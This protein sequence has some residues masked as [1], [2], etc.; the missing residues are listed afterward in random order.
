MSCSPPVLHLPS[1]NIVVGFALGR[2]KNVKQGGRYQEKWL[3][4]LNLLNPRQPGQGQR[5]M[6]GEY[7]VRTDEGKWDHIW[8]RELINLEV[9]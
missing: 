9:V 4:L 5:T 1:A 7:I 6:A 2:E 8:Q 3:E